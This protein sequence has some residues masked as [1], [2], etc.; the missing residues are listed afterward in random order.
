MKRAVRIILRLI[1]S[2]LILF[3]GLEIGLEIIRQRAKE[4]GMRL[5]SCIAGAFLIALGVALIAVSSRVAARLTEDF[6]E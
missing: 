1:A 6:E 2:G 3:G 4:G 5:W